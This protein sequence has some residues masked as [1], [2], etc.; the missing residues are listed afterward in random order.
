[1]RVEGEGISKGYL[2]PGSHRHVVDKSTKFWGGATRIPD[3][4][5][6]ET[7]LAGVLR[8]PSEPSALPKRSIPDVCRFA[9]EV[10]EL[11]PF[12]PRT[13]TSTQFE[14]QRIPRG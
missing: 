14:R 1:M 11:G 10:D 2:V 6:P 13:C 3:L 12:N 9:L 7:P 8:Y 5:G 4:Q